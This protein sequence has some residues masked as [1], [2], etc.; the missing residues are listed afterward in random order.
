MIYEVIK[1][2]QGKTKK[3]TLLARKILQSK[4]LILQ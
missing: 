4:G 3:G 1:S 2:V